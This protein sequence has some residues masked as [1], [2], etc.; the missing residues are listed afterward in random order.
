MEWSLDV[1]EIR[2]HGNEYTYKPAEDSLILYS[3][4][5]RILRGYSVV[6][7]VGT[8]SGIISL[9]AGRNGVYSIGI[10]TIYDATLYAYKNGVLNGLDEYMDY[11]CGD[12]LEMLRLDLDDLLLVSNPPYLPGTYEYPCDI[13]Y[14][15]GMGGIEVI[16]RLIEYFS[17]SKASEMYFVASS[18]T[19]MD[20]IIR[21]SPEFKVVIEKIDEIRIMSEI[22]YLYRV[23]HVSS[24]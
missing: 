7:D 10:D 20:N 15:G 2:L 8:G 22:I 1:D 4:L 24:T 21:L 13:L 17:I 5:R 14:I 19:D 12:M 3:R 9:I 6:Y 16:R 18:Y 23:R 11:I